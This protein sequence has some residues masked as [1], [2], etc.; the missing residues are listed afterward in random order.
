MA[1]KMSVQARGAGGQAQP[2]QLRVL[3]VSAVVLAVL[4][5][6]GTFFDLQ[7]DTAINAAGNPIVTMFSTL[8][9][10]TMMVP[11]C[12]FMGALTACVLASRVASPLKVIGAVAAQLFAVFVGVI[13]VSSIFSSDGIG[14]LLPFAVPS[15]VSVVLGILVGLGLEVPGYRAAHRST[16]AQLGRR[17]LIVVCALLLAYLCAELIKRGMTR[18]RYRLLL[19]GYE[20]I[21]FHPWYSRFTNAAE[22]MA[23]YGIDSNEFHS[24][25]SG[26][27][28]MTASLITSYLGI[29]KL[30]PSL[31]KSWKPVVVGSVVLLAVI[32]VC[33]MMLGAHFLSDVSLGALIGVG[34]GIVAQ[35][36]DARFSQ[37]YPRA[38]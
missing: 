26:H 37:R 38:R 36:I 20:G 32:M 1:V 24:F 14:P 15:A 29:T 23:R 18:P 27:C 34:F 31:E 2:L 35:H 12:V 13:L 22:L 30:W 9:L 6:V 28:L 10:F 21:E 3:W 8:G 25:P 16:D 4:F 17:I 5:L 33:R 11:A 19:L 7:I